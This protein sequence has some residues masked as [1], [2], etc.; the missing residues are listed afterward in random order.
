MAADEEVGFVDVVGTV[1]P[2]ALAV[3][4]ARNAHHRVGELVVLTMIWLDEDGN[5]LNEKQRTML[6]ANAS[7]M[8]DGFE[9]EVLGKIL[10]EIK[11]IRV[12]RDPEAVV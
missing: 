11:R 5:P 7:R 2:H 9:N 10:D 12:D 6:A 4:I 8:F 1:E 3:Q